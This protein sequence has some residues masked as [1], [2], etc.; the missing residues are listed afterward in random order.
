MKRMQKITRISLS[1]LCL[2]SAMAVLLSG[3]A[4]ADSG[5]FSGDYVNVSG[6][7]HLSISDA[8]IAA[9]AQMALGDAGFNAQVDGGLN[10]SY[11]TSNANIYNIN[12]LFYYRMPEGQFGGLVDYI[13]TI[14][15]HSG[16]VI[17][18]GAFG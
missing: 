10:S 1:A 7:N 8:G 14:G 17:P 15:M 16:H 12:G 13:S 3:P 18:A 4:A 9:S 11:G 6:S 2:G 5:V